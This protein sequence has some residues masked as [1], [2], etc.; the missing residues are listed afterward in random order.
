MKLLGLLVK[1]S[2]ERTQEILGSIQFSSMFRSDW[3]PKQ[4]AQDRWELI[5]KLGGFKDIV[6]LIPRTKGDGTHRRLDVFK[7]RPKNFLHAGE[8]AGTHLFSVDIPDE[9]EGKMCEDILVGLNFCPPS[10]HCWSI[11]CRDDNDGKEYLYI[12]IY[13]PTIRRV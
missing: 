8:S 10:G 12:V 11:A 7:G 3:S 2:C 9:F 5:E 1:L 13:E 4:W 6:I